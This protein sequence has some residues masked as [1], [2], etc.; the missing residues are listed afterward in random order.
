MRLSPTLLPILALFMF[1]CTKDSKH[2]SV[3]SPTGT[4]RGAASQFTNL[5]RYSGSDYSQSISVEYANELIGSYLKSVDYP[6]LDTAIRS[7]AYDAD[8]LRSYLAD[9]SIKTIRFHMAHS[10]SYYNTNKDQYRGLSAQSL[11]LVIVGYGNE[12]NM[13]RNNQNG[14]YE[15][16]YPCPATCRINDIGLLQ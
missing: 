10:P 7:F 6:R 3:A 16:C 4:P 15:H 13:I 14:V 1:S 9:T 12:D 5:A 8:T 11:T 2:N